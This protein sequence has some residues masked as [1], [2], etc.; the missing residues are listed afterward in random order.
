MRIYSFLEFDLSK[1]NIP[2]SIEF[3]PFLPNNK[4]IIISDQQKIHTIFSNLLQNAIKHSKGTKIEFGYTLSQNT[5]IFYVTDT[6]V[7]IPKEK[8]DY[9]LTGNMFTTSSFEGANEGIGLGLYLSHRLVHLLGGKLWVDYSDKNGTKI[10]F[11]IV[12]KPGK[13]N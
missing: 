10:C 8:L 9:F 5:V 2:Q 12:Y 6:G 13:L 11:S 1:K 4:D 7:G 3:K